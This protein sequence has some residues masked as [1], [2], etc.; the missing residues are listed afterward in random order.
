[1]CREGVE[2]CCH[3]VAGSVFVSIRNSFVEEGGRGG[4]FLHSY[5]HQHVGWGG[6]RYCV[7]GDGVC[8]CCYAEG[9]ESRGSS[10]YFLLAYLYH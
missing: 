2:G 7:G 6:G 1:M 5:L 4:F 9:K 3:V 8:M 10:I